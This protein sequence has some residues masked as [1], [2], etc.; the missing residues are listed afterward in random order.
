MGVGKKGKTTI[1]FIVHNI[2]GGEL[3]PHR[4]VNFGATLNKAELYT[5]YRHRHKGVNILGITSI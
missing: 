3:V 4:D 2:I 1:G 5:I